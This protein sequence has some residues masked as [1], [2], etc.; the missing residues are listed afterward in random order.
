MVKVVI[1]PLSVKC[2]KCDM[3]KW[4][5]CIRLSGPYGQGNP[6]R[7]VHNERGVEARQAYIRAARA[8]GE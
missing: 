7:K 6:L 1:D 8:K 3:P 2:P 4:Q 5:R